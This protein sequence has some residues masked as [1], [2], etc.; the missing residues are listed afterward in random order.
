MVPVTN[1]VRQFVEYSVFIHTDLG[2][3]GDVTLS[4]PTRS[5][6]ASVTILSRHLNTIIGE[7]SFNVRTLRNQLR[8]GLRLG[9][10]VHILLDFVDVSELTTRTVVRLITPLG[11]VGLES[12]GVRTMSTLVLLLAVFS[13]VVVILV[14]D[15]TVVGTIEH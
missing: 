13:Q 5:T 14:F 12:F 1:A 8:V 4:R 10:L 7:E 6:T 3:K 15:R 2:V 9:D 11:F